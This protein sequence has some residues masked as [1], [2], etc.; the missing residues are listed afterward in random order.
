[1]PDVMALDEPMRS[2]LLFGHASDLRHLG[3]INV[4][5]ENGRV[6][7]PPSHPTVPRIGQIAT[8]SPR[9]GSTRRLVSISAGRS[10]PHRRNTPASR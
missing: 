2:L 10:A 9:N 6:T 5:D 1:M 7:A 8:T 4:L 3:F